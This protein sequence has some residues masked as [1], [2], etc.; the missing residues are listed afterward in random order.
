MPTATAPTSVTLTGATLNGTVDAGNEVTDVRFRVDDNSDFSSSLTTIDATQSPLPAANGGV[1]VSVP[2][3]GLTTGTTY[4]V[5]V[6]ADNGTSG[7]FVNSAPVSF[8]PSALQA[9]TTG[10][11]SNVTSSSARLA[12]TV[13]PN[14][15][16][17]QAR[18]RYGTSP[19]STQYT[20]IINA[21][22]GTSAV[23][24]EADI[25]GLPANR[26]IYYTLRTDRV[27]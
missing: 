4:Y 7:A 26:R 25:T 27:N 18:F 14:G 9:V 17:T 8:I 22:A 11:F 19:N 20:P 13:T 3:T 2:I 23:P 21:G 5:R 10:V 24:V 12:G 1:A 15:L 6:E 16:A